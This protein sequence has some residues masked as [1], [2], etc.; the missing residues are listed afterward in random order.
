M[1]YF[2][3]ISAFHEIWRLNGEF[4]CAEEG[5]FILWDDFD[6]DYFPLPPGPPPQPGDGPIFG[7]SDIPTE[8]YPFSGHPPVQQPFK[9]TLVPLWT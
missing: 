2:L 4:F 5:R 3:M 6:H 1:G 7:D 8:W 9:F